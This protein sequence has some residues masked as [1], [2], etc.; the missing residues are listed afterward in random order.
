MQSVN[1]V[2]HAVEL[3]D[4]VNVS[5]TAAYQLR[6]EC[7]ISQVCVRELDRLVFLAWLVYGGDLVD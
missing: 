3:L 4:L 5:V 1:G 6:N 2:H 7:Q